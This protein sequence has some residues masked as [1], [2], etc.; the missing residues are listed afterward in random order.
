MG[1]SNAASIKALIK[2]HIHNMDLKINLTAKLIFHQLITD[3]K[4]SSFV[5]LADF[6]PLVEGN[7]REDLKGILLLYQ[8]QL[9][10]FIICSDS[11][12]IT[13]IH[14]IL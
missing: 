11:P 9:Q 8:C 1:A 4:W 3:I 7:A 5:Y 13:I 6:L 2:F 12:A 14:Y 10:M